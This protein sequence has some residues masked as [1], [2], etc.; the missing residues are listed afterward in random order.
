MTDTNNSSVSKAEEEDVKNFHETNSGG[1]QGSYTSQSGAS[2]NANNFTLAQSRLPTG[3]QHQSLQQPQGN[4]SSSS[5]VLIKQGSIGF[6]LPKVQVFANKQYLS[7]NSRQSRPT[8]S[9]GQV[10]LEHF[11]A[12]MNPTAL[13]VAPSKS[14]LLI[15]DTVLK[16]HRESK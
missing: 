12:Q 13:K 11:E 6:N 15:S 9:P 7:I 2:K 1:F 4:T 16:Q 8:R 10:E 5:H 3:S 14:S